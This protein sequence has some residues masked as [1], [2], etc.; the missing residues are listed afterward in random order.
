MMMENLKESEIL[1]NKLGG[2]YY[3][4]DFWVLYKVSLNSIS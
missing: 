2:F 3:S 1:I 4:N